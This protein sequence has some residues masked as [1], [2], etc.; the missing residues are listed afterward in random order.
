VTSRRLERRE[1]AGVTVFDDTYNMNPASSRAA[2]SALAGLPRRGRKIVVFGEMLELGER[3]R[4]LHLELGDAVARSGVD[5]LVAVGD[6]AR[7][8]AE[9]AIATGLSSRSV[10]CV[11][12]STRALELLVDTVRPQDLVLCKASRKV[13]L[14]RLVDG[15]LDRLRHRGSADAAADVAAIHSE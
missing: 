6:G 10:V 5:L 12:D 1:V 4:D 15:L 13:G 11:A 14:D 9:G 2:L 7:G 3:K 8:I